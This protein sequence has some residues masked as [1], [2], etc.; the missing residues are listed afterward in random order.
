M[1]TVVL[2]AFTVRCNWLWVDGTED[3]SSSPLTHEQFLEIEVFNRSSWG[4]KSC[5]FHG[6][7]GWTKPGTRWT[8]GSETTRPACNFAWDHSSWTGLDNNETMT[9]ELKTELCCDYKTSGSG[10]T[11]EE[12]GWCTYIHKHIHERAR[13]DDRQFCHYANGSWKALHNVCSLSR[14]A[15]GFGELE[16]KP[17]LDLKARNNRKNR[18]K[19]LPLLSEMHPL[20]FGWGGCGGLSRKEATESGR[21]EGKDSL[22]VI[23]RFCRKKKRCGRAADC[24]W[25]NY[26][27]LLMLLPQLAADC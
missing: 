12:G 11:E 19:P 2:K 5:C 26:F 7:V 6:N 14:P 18:S 4:K 10:T 23:R 15:R 27:C 13:P 3:S 21:W 17:P 20:D 1:D 9:I 22:W 16:G 8:S 25:F 24:C